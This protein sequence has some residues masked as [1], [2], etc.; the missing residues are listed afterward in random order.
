[1]S[2]RGTG[3]RSKKRRF[4]R[5]STEVRRAAL[6][7]ALHAEVP[8]SLSEHAADFSAPDVRAGDD[9]DLDPEC[10]P[11]NVNSWR[12]DRNRKAVTAKRR[13]LYIV[14][15]DYTAPASTTAGSRSNSSSDMGG[16]RAGDS[17]SA[18]ADGRSAAAAV[19]CSAGAGGAEG[20]PSL[21]LPSIADIAAYVGASYHGMPVKLLPTMPLVP[22]ADAPPARKG[23]RRGVCTSAASAA[24]T[25]SPAG[26]GVGSKRARPTTAA[27]A[28]SSRLPPA[29]VRTSASEVRVRCRRAPDGLF[30]RQLNLNDLLDAVA[31]ELPADGYAII[32]ITSHDLYEVDEEDG[33]DEE[34]EDLFTCGRAYGGSRIAVVSAARYSPALDATA[35]VAFAESWPLGCVHKHDAALAALK[36]LPEPA[37]P[38]ELTGLWLGRMAR[39]AAHE[40]GHCFGLEHCVYY[41]CCMQGAAHLRED[42]RQPPHLC[43]VDLRKV[44][45]ATGADAAD[46][47]AALL[48]FCERPAM[49]HVHLFAA[50]AAWLRQRLQR[51]AG[52]LPASCVSGESAGAAG[53][54]AEP[55]P[56][57]G[58]TRA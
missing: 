54:R 40:L 21:S 52:G 3:A 58:T 7:L 11:Q 44:L 43:P 48:A 2:S 19:P 39:T 51:L 4:V 1:M 37:S 27:A 26:A 36:A 6:G 55:V 33:A 38:A 46:R 31:E 56:T 24:S 8:P 15:V 34:E 12:T 32:G 57:A 49:S 16:K 5:P 47:Y 25:V 14:P 41:A 17:H 50:F 13:T 45:T 10:P 42:M 35:G 29:A 30:A 20:A 18:A 9:L 23:T 22:W 53:A 28:P